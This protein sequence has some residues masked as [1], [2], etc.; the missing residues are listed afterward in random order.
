MRIPHFSKVF[1]RTVSFY[2]EVRHLH[3]NI[4]F[5][6][7]AWWTGRNYRFWPCWGSFELRRWR[8]RLPPLASPASQHQSTLRYY[9]LRY[10]WWLE[11]CCE[12]LWFADS[13]G[14]HP[15]PYHDI[16]VWLHQHP[17][18][19]SG[20]NTDCGWNHLPSTVLCRLVHFCR[21]HCLVCLSRHNSYGAYTRWT[22]DV[23]RQ[24]RGTH[25]VRSQLSYFANSRYFVPANALTYTPSSARPTVTQTVSAVDSL[26]ILH[27]DSRWLVLVPRLRPRRTMESLQEL[28]SAPL[29]F[30]LS[31]LLRF[32]AF[33]SLAPKEIVR[34]WIHISKLKVWHLAFWI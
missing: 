33:W 25:H 28:S 27:I 26:I 32:S 34:L 29:L 16:P 24:I 6:A 4:F 8:S 18:G 23:H 21:Q 3:Q 20:S 5:T 19:Y 31:L 1:R 11:D 7:G 15:D 22:I 2:F 30:P 13:D 10:Q 14:F 12:S 17:Y 9:W